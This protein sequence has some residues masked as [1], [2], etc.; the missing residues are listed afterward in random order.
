VQWDVLMAFLS[1]L[2]AVGAT[3][4]SLWRAGRHLAA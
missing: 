4:M 1:L 2:P 3:R